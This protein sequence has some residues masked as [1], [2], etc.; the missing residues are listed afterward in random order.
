[1]L[2]LVSA[3][4]PCL[5]S[6]SCHKK[7][8]LFE[9]EKLHQ[10]SDW[11]AIT[12]A[13]AFG[14]VRFTTPL[15]HPLFAIWK[16]VSV[17]YGLQAGVSSTCRGEDN[18]HLFQTQRRL[19]SKF[20]KTQINVWKIPLKWLKYRL[21]KHRVNGASRDRVNRAS[22]ACVACPNDLPLLLVSLEQ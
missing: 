18:I 17:T 9:F 22:S 4:L 21:F 1:M 11:K 6:S 19:V 15:L 2:S 3:K 8:F 5:P 16:I 14:P 7:N 12:S 20:I 13:L 10:Y